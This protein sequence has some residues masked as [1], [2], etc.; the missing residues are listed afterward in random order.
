[1][2]QGSCLGHQVLLLCAFPFA[3]HP[4]DISI[5]LSNNNSTPLSQNSQVTTADLFVMS[6]CS[7]HFL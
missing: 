2:V 5:D 3:S 1:M 4:Y 7:S 6:D